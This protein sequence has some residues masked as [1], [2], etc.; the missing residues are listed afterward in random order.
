[1]TG[2]KKRSPRKQVDSETADEDNS[3][4]HLDKKFKMSAEDFDEVPDHSQVKFEAGV[5]SK[6]AEPESA[7]AEKQNH[8]IMHGNFEHYYGCRK[9]DGTFKPVSYSEPFDYRLHYIPKDAFEQ[10][11]VLDI[12]CNS[13]EVTIEIGTLIDNILNILS[14]IFQA[15]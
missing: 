14:K 3:T 9:V 7:K 10:K 13:G 15:F 1:M 11:R 2:F 8:R 12:G 4:K 6:N 5:T